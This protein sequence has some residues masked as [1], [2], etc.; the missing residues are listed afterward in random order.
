MCMQTHIVHA[1]PDLYIAGGRL[2]DGF[3]SCVAVRDRRFKTN[4]FALSKPTALNEKR[5]GYDG[6]KY[7]RGIR[8][9]SRSHLVVLRHLPSL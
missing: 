1:V 8:R 3:L 6:R 4:S 2:G 7:F 9:R 5:K